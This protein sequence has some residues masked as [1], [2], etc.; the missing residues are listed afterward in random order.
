MCPYSNKM[1][2]WRTKCNQF[3]FRMHLVHNITGVKHLS[4]FCL[5]GYLFRTT[6]VIWSVQCFAITLLDNYR[7]HPAVSRSSGCPHRGAVGGELVSQHFLC[8]AEGSSHSGAERPFCSVCNTHSE[9]WKSFHWQNGLQSRTLPCVCWLLRVQT[10]S[11]L[12]RGPTCTIL[13][14]K[15][16]KHE[17]C[18]TNKQTKKKALTLVWQNKRCDFHAVNKAIKQI[19]PTSGACLP[20]RYS[21]NSAKQICVTLLLVVCDFYATGPHR[22]MAPE[23]FKKMQ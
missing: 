19:I 5:R 6:I 13:Y 17:D 10:H 22:S 2:F 11:L 8:A 14:K 7:T 3:S 9:T 20:I 21:V 1:C 16:K 18:C 15:K 12:L 23:T 4:T